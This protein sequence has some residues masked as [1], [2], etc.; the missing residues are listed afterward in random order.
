MWLRFLSIDLAF[1]ISISKYTFELAVNSFYLKIRV[2]IVLNER[3]HI[4]EKEGSRP[5]RR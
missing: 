1:K 4:A 3:Q 2:D 5:A